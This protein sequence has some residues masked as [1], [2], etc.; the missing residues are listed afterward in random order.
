MKS[1]TDIPATDSRFR[2]KSA[3][4]AA[5]IAALK[6]GSKSALETKRENEVFAPL[7]RSARIDPGAS[8]RL[9]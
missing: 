9:A 5:D 3:S 4:R 8:E 7:A 2:S 1:R 6:S